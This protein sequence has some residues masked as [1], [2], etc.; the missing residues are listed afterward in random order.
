[1]F[2]DLTLGEEITHGTIPA[3]SVI[4]LTLDSTIQPSTEKRKRGRPRKTT[5][6][7]LVVS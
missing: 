1:I 4:D 3:S 2:I 7:S 5:G 6:Q